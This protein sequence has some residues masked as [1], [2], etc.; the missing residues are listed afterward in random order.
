MV[1][2]FLVQL[3]LLNRCEDYWTYQHTIGS[4]NSGAASGSCVEASPSTLTWLQTAQSY[5]ITQC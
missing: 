5:K 2:K 4:C 3:N 1:Q